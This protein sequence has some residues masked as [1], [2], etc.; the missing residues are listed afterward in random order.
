MEFL[1]LVPTQVSS[2]FPAFLAGFLQGFFSCL[3]TK[4]P[5]I[6]LDVFSDVFFTISFLGSV[7]SPNKAF[8]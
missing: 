1:G 6:F 2:I 3:R 8:K 4:T 7:W 5:L